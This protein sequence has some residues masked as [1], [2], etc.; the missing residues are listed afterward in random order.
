MGKAQDYFNLKQQKPNLA[1]KLH[2]TIHVQRP[3]QRT[4]ISLAVAD[5]CQY[6]G[7]LQRNGVSA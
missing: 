5:A 7:W 3:I 6:I 1:A 2:E 4:I